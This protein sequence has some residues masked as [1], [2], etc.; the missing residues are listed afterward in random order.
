M[1]MRPVAGFLRYGGHF[2]PSVKQGEEDHVQGK[3]DHQVQ[4]QVT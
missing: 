4:D 3:C 1:F 2:V